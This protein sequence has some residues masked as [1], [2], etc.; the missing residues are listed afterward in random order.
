M[1][2]VLLLPLEHVQGHAPQLLGFERLYNNIFIYSNFGTVNE[3]V[4]SEYILII[5][6]YKT[7]ALKVTK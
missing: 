4:C 1:E 2:D 5:L 6:K 3:K 7:D